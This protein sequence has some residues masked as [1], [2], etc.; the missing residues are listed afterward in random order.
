MSPTVLWADFEGLEKDQLYD[1]LRLRNEVFI[2]E[3]QSLFPDLDGLDQQARHLL[4]MLDGKLAGYLRLRGPDH[5]G[6][7]EIIL[8]RVVLHKDARGQG[9]G[10]V[11]MEAAL[12]EA[13]RRYPDVPVSL[14]AQIDQEAFYTSLGFKRIPGEPYDDAGIL[15]IDMRHP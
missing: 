9:L 2:V 6:G 13:R 7:R 5:H 4:L 3:Q 12:A 11:I 14:S 10:R 1:L 15:H 8:S